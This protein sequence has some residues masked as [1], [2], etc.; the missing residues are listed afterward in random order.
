MN[1]PCFSIKVVTNVSGL[2]NKLFVDMEANLL[3]S[4]F[5]FP[6]SHKE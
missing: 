3:H 6:H 1:S 5:L 2:Y 4:I